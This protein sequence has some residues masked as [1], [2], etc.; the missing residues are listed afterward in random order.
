MPNT[1]TRPNINDGGPAFP[2]PHDA[3]TDE[4]GVRGYVSEYCSI[5]KGMTLRDYFAAQAMLALV[6]HRE[7]SL[8]QTYTK[9]ELAVEAYHYADAMLSARAALQE[10]DH[11]EQL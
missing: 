10:Q 7:R 6:N 4:N 1:P 11:A 3:I 2:V 8:C 9:G 5:D